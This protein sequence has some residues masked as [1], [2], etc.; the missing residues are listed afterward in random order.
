LNLPEKSLNT[1]L[2]NMIGKS[3]KDMN[4]DDMKTLFDNKNHRLEQLTQ[5]IC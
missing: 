1:G 3:M 4:K 5:N 2:V